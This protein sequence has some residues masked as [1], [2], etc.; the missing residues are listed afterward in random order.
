[1]TFKTPRD[2]L[3]T[4]HASDDVERIRGLN[5]V[6]VNELFNGAPPLSEDEA[7]RW[8]IKVNCNW[9]EAPVLAQHARRQ[10]YNAFL[11]PG[12]FFRVSLPTAD[13][14][15]Q[16]HWS[17]IITQQINRSMKLSLEYFEV[18]RS[19]F[20]CVVAHGIGA[21]IWDTPDQWLPRYVAIEDLRVPTDT[22]V[23]LRNLEWF[24]ERRRYTYGELVA[25]VFSE[26][27][28]RG[29]N[30]KVVA[31]LLK[32]YADKNTSAVTDFDWLEQP[33]KAAELV[34][35]NIGY[36]S[37]DALPTIP[38]WNFFYRDQNGARARW[39]LAVV[40][41]ESIN[42]AGS[43]WIYKSEKPFASNLNRILHVQFGDLNN[44][45]PFLWHSVRS[46]GFLLMEPCFWTNLMRCRLVQHVM[47]SMNIWFRV[48]DPVDRDRAQ[49]IELF[50][51]CVVPSGVE[52]VPQTQRHQVDSN[53]I[54]A[55]MAQLRQLM[56]EAS[57]SYTQ[58]IDTGT[59]KEQTATETMAKV[60]QVNAMMSGLLSTAFMYETF[61]Y[62][63][64]CRRFCLSST[65]DPDV[66][67]FQSECRRQGVPREWLNSE[68]WEITP[69]V[70]VGSGNP[71]MEVTQAQAL[72]QHRPLYSPS[73][74]AQ[75]L[76]IFTEAVTGNPTL[77]ESLAPQAAKRD[78]TDAQEIAGAAFGSLIQGVVPPVRENVP[79]AE[80]CEVL[81]GMLAGKI[82]AVA[83][84]EG[85]PTPQELHGMVTA[86]QFI[87]ERIQLLAQDQNQADLARQFADD[88][89]NLD[90]EIKAFGQRLAE[91]Q[92]AQQAQADPAAMAKA[93]A[94]QVQAQQK[95]VIAEQQ[96]KLRARQ[97][98]EAFQAEQS[99]RE[100]EFIAEQRRLDAEAA[101][102][103]ERSLALAAAEV[104]A[105]KM[106]AE[107]AASAAGEGESD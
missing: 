16:A 47:D 97:Q 46:L 38:M 57:S 52:I 21:Q 93:Q 78:I 83:R 77:A 42:E 24:A 48:N 102:E 81:I 4:I 60:A 20:S 103:I 101:A 5:R 107:A 8:N 59:S 94:A 82:A 73:A 41:D 27:S 56:S 9:G 3:K 80:L 63:E 13:P 34:K 65:T 53:L 51:K 10:Y 69:E 25:K 54:G 58:E 30:R 75:I 45:A 105:K 31:A 70:P 1:M 71:V 40:P 84:T 37:S 99:R 35:Q 7:R 72:M 55:T 104:E 36:F 86:S 100:A 43:E 90:N 32:R 66:Q 62:R 64:I 92:Q 22:E 14:R 39:Y 26:N 95:V 18:V 89:G 15:N 98:L 61:A 44:K 87:A 85:V 96:H 28:D 91:K 6:K 106:A 68:R 12:M 79:P 23:S 67:K 50:D 49:K 88:L 74:Q 2:V 17:S 76:H 29:W 33:E 11:K 19:K